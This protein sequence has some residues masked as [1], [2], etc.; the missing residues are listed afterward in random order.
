MKKFVLTS[1]A[2]L[3]MACAS[4]FTRNAPPPLPSK[5][6]AAPMLKDKTVAL[7]HVD[8]PKN[9]RAYCTGVW[10]SESSILTAH[11]CMNDA[12]TGTKIHYVVESDVFE[13]RND[14]PQQYQPK[15]KIVPRE[16]LVSALDP[17]H[18]LALLRSVMPVRHGVA[19]LARQKILP[20]QFAQQVGQ[21]L[22]MWWSYSSGD[23]G[24]VRWQD[25]GDGPMLWVQTTVPTSPGNSGGGIFNAKGE[26]IGICH[27][28]FLRGQLINVF[29]HPIYVD[30]FLDKQGPNL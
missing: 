21:S 12:P 2:I 5:I 24:A 9:I 28:T 7:V 11:H 27:G 18:D 8:D 3:L 20:G 25:A 15:K 16:A 14:I 19:K 13:V 4:P 23:I 10:V 30:S 26:L 22:G 17:P 1:L 29:I 6:D